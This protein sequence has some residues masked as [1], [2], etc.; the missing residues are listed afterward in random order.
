MDRS[1]RV[2]IRGL[3]LLRTAEF[4]QLFS[5]MGILTGIGLMTIKYVF[6]GN[7]AVQVA[8]KSAATLAMMLPPYGGTMMTLSTTP[9]S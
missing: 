9:F 6:T 4:W 7:L 5:I 3:K 1:H 8:D 2:D